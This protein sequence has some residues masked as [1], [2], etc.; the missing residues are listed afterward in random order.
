MSICGPQVLLLFTRAGWNAQ[1]YY[2]N[3][4]IK[5]FFLKNLDIRISASLRGFFM[6]IAGVV[7]CV[8]LACFAPWQ[9][10]LLR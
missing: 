10:I 3:F 2:I 8:K 9:E 4:V 1:P 6:T 5:R 7:Y